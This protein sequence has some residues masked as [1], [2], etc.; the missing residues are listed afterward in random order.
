VELKDI[1][2][3]LNRSGLNDAAVARA[4]AEAGVETTQAT[5]NRLKNGVHKST[6]FELGLAL[7]SLHRKRCKTA[8]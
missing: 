4:L 5:I 8:A 3:D 7:L 2:S 1:I 6:K